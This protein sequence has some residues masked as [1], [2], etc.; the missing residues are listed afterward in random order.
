MSLSTLTT[1]VETIN[2]TSPGNNIVQGVLNTTFQP[3]DVINGNGTS[4]TFNLLDNSTANFAI[5]VSTTMTGLT[6]VNVAR[7]ATGGG[8]GA[9]TITNSTFGTGLKSLSY[10]DSSLTGS[11]TAAA[12][13]VT[14]N[15]ATS[16]ALTGNAGG[17]AFT[18][19]AVTDTATTVTTGSTL[20]TVS[21]TGTTGNATLTGNGI[22]T[23]NL[24]AAVTGGTAT[25]TA[26]AGTRALTINASGTTNQGAVT[27]ATATSL[28]VNV[29]G[30]QTLGLVTAAK[31]TVATINTTA[32]ATTSISTAIA[33]T[34]NI[35]GSKS[36]ALTV[37][38]PALTSAVITGAG[39]V[40]VDLSAIT[41]LTSIDTTGSTAVLA[42]TANGL[43]GTTNNVL[44]IGTG[45]AVTGG[46]G[47]DFITV[48]ATSKA[49]S[50]GG[51]NNQV[52]L[53]AGTTAVGTGGSIAG[54]TGSADVLALANADAVTLSTAGAA[55]TAFKAAVT[56]FE[57]LDIGVAA[58]ST[59]SVSGFG[60][61]NQ[62]NVTTAAQTQTL[63]GVT[64]GFTLKT[65]L[66]AAA[67]T[68][69]TTNNLAGTTDVIN[70]SLNAD[71]SAA[72]A[73]F[74]TFTLP[75]TETLNLSLVDT[76]ATFT[77]RLAT[78]TITDAGLQSLV[79]TGN[80]GITIG[81][82]SVAITN[83]DASGLTKGAVQWQ[84]GALV[85]SSVAKGSLTGGDTLNLSASIATTNIT[86]TAGTN[87]VLGSSSVA[88][89]ITGGSG[90]DTITG[91]TAIDTI[92]SGA[93]ADRIYADNQGNKEVQTLTLT[94]VAAV[95]G[96]VLINSVLVTYTGGADATADGVALAAAINANTSLTGLVTA[97]QATGVVTVTSLTD[98]DLSTI[99]VVNAA[100]AT[101]VV[102]TTTAGTAGTAAADVINGGSGNDIIVGGGGNDA[103]TSGA[104]A[105]T[106]FF[107]KP[108]SIVSGGTTAV[109]SDFV[110]TSTTSGDRIIL[111]NQAAV[112]GTVTTVQDLSGTASFAAAVNAAALGNALDNGTVVFIFGGNEYVYVETTGAGATAATTDFIVQLTGTPA[113]AGTAITGNFILGV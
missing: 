56:G 55:Q 92:T 26:A 83:F 12:V 50:L 27:D 22:T 30:A 58:T 13:S 73:A 17:G 101:A 4:T 95:T 44:T 32:A 109:I 41:T 96:S 6:A 68:S 107:L 74:G 91:G 94:H 98:G 31:A 72:A 54:G 42:T 78:A 106:F 90:A 88:N 2:A 40:T 34:L 111:G 65:T 29:S 97:T 75:G 85:G 77:T 105:D 46:A 99:T 104:G 87:I 84:S 28:T 45:A 52:T 61:F 108:Q 112:V 48:G 25:I 103:I 60:T 102:A 70:V 39:G 19:A 79:I 7:L 49:I 23:L 63:S 38:A 69:L 81:A 93:G 86:V 35:G 20:N 21:L 11:M 18:T 67:L 100:A 16:V 1:N 8:T 36:N 14:L 10:N 59:I 80:N 9:V 71:L 33:T 113:A 57:I 51:G 62:V 43:T 82:N 64:T 110:T 5:P 89:T 15:S 53:T 76:N 47:N 3:F 66:G 37:T 24:N